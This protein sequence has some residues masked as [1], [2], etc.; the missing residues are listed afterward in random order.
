M[1]TCVTCASRQCL[2]DTQHLCIKW[3]A[4]FDAQLVQLDVYNSWHGVR[5]MLYMYGCNAHKMHGLLVVHVHPNMQR[6]MF[7]IHAAIIQISVQRVNVM[8]L[9][10]AKMNWQ[11]S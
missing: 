3:H 11:V 1:C 5:L 6:M 7:G 4:H 9:D 8:G 10:P 2:C